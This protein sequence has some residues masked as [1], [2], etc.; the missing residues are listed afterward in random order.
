MKPFWKP[1][2]YYYLRDKNKIMSFKKN[3]LSASI[4]AIKIYILIC[5]FSNSDE[6]GNYCALLTYDQ[7]SKYGALS[8]K[9]VRN[10]LK[11]LS[12]MELIDDEGIKKK[13]Y[14][15]VGVKRTGTSFSK[16]RFSSSLGFWAKMPFTGLVDDSGR[17]TAFE[18]MSN[19]SVVELNSLKLFLYLLSIRSKDDVFISVTLSKIK[20]KLAISFQEIMLSIAFMQSIGMIYKV[21]LGGNTI[22]K[23]DEAFSIIFF[24]CGWEG[25]AWKP[26]Y[27][28]NEDFKDRVL[29]NIFPEFEKN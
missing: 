7:L 3:D 27:L 17:V 14:Y 2:P 29:N 5:L 4:A 16:T 6:Y 23:Y 20:S 12:E 21:N 10:G 26:K 24:V 22:S 18:A 28:S 8:R 9:L 11:K 13:K 15:L 19:R 1:M 25:L